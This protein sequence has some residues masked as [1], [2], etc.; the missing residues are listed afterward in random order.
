MEQ[1]QNQAEQTQEVVNAEKTITVNGRTYE[2]NSDDQIRMKVFHTRFASL[3]TLAFVLY[4]ICAAIEIGACA[5]MYFFAD[6]LFNDDVYIVAGNAKGNLVLKVLNW[7]IET[8]QGNTFDLISTL[9]EGF[10]FIALGLALLEGLKGFSKNWQGLVTAYII[11]AG[12][13]T[14]IQ[15]TSVG[16]EP[17]MGLL[18]I[19]TIVT[20]ALMIIIGFGMLSCFS[21]KGPELVGGLTLAIGA[22]SI[23]AIFFISHYE[24]KISDPTSLKDYISAVKSLGLTSGIGMAL[25]VWAGVKLIENLKSEGD[26]EENSDDDDDDEEDDD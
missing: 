25:T 22:I 24:G 18:K 6:A 8:T 1:E 11:A 16:S 21:G 15:L 3:A 7:C 17:N 4:A 23:A 14:I 26:D 9:A 20:G 12:I 2:Y 10:F 5:G 13:F 19:G